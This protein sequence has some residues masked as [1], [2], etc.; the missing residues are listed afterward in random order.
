MADDRDTPFGLL[1]RTL[2]HSWSPQIHARLGSAPYALF[3]REPDEVEDFLRTGAWRG[4]NVTIPYKRQAAETAD[5]RSARVEALGVANTLVRLDDGTIL[6]DNTDV[7][8]FNAM[9]AAFCHTH[10]HESPR[11]ALDGRKALVLGTGGA[12]QAVAYALREYVGAEVVFVSRTGESTYDDLPKR[13]A[14]ATLVVNATPVGM[15]PHCPASPLADEV[16]PAMHEL[17]GVL[18][19]IYNPLRTGLVMQAERAGIP[20]ESGLSMLVWQA[21]FAS[22]LFQD[23]DL[24]DTLADELLGSLGASQTNI[25]LVG[26]PGAG[27]TSAGRALAH[28]LGRPFVDLD[29]AFA[30]TWGESAEQCIR[31]RGEDVFRTRET[32]VAADYGARS[33]LVIACGGGIVVRDAN[34][35]LLHQNGTVVYLDRPLDQLSS[36][37]RPV[38]QRTGVERLATERTHLYERWC[39]LRISCTGSPQGDASLI[40]ARLGL[41]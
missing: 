30:L 9:L 35:P 22:E 6:A 41:A 39:D 2:G 19:V 13:H 23:V 33:G 20:C 8:G 29:A 12:A 21:V 11:Q 32:Q 4:L 26:M 27:K 15:F 3:E 7:L 10:L 1:G 40:C 25:V 28:L 17:R 34:Y 18:D 37:G 5:R 14:D 31:T 24:P 36:E 16:L 38:S